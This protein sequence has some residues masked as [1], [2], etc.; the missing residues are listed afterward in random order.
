MITTLLG[1]FLGI[2]FGAVIAGPLGAALGAVVGT[3][4]GMLWAGSREAVQPLPSDGKVVHEEQN[5]MCENKGRVATASFL[6][7]AHTGAWLDV[8]KCSLCDPNDQVQ[9]AKRCLLLIRGVLP[10]S[11]HPVET[12]A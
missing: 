5:L 10:A 6:R 11:K 9:C 2:L 4:I 8:E 1:A 12:H 7:D 3:A